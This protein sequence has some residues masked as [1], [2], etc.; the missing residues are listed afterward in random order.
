MSAHVVVAGEEAMTQ[1]SEIRRAGISCAAQRR[2]SA[3][4]LERV[5]YM[6]EEWRR[7]RQLGG[8]YVIRRS[9]R[10]GRV[11]RECKQ[12]CEGEVVME[13]RTSTSSAHVTPASP[14]IQGEQ[15]GAKASGAKSAKYL[16]EAID[17]CRLAGCR[18]YSN[19]GC[20]YTTL[21]RGNEWT[22]AGA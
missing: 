1:R 7:R 18:G 15:E 4:P 6:S 10:C 12:A 14:T 20:G 21:A 9:G 5:E 17:T 16:R 3:V 13:T 22:D 8:L 19:S 2:V 11:G